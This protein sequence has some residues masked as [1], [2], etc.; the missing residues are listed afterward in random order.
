MLFSSLSVLGLLLWLLLT[1]VCERPQ[2]PAWR[3]RNV[4]KLLNAILLLLLILVTYK[5]L[6]WHAELRF[7]I[8]IC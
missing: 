2:C 3:A 1:M 6:L 7:L 8:Q 5:A 4:Y